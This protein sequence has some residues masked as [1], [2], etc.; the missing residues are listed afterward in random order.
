MPA[1]AEMAVAGGG[2][3]G[4]ADVTTLVG[5]TDAVAPVAAALSEPH[6][7]VTNRHNASPAQAA[8]CNKLLTIFSTHPG[9][10]EN[11]SFVTIC[12]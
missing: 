11:R 6:P 10:T 3:G 2:A 9:L 8:R 5:P 7:V 1:A 12:C 4:G